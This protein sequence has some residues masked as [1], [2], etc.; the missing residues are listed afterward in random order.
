MKR[1]FLTK[2]NEYLFTIKEGKIGTNVL[3]GFE[4]INVIV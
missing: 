4:K 3:V 1:I 2:G